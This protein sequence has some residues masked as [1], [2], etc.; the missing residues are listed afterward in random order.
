MYFSFQ[1]YNLISKIFLYIIYIYITNDLNLYIYDVEVKL[2][3][4]YNRDK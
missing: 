2:Y 1:S 4:K 3:T